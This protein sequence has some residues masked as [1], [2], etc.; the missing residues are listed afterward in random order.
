MSSSPTWTRRLLKKNPVHSFTDF[1]MHMN[2]LGILKNFR[3]WFR[4]H[5]SS[6]DFPFLLS[7]TYANLLESIWV[8]R[9]LST[10]NWQSMQI[11]LTHT[12]FFHL[13]MDCHVNMKNNNNIC[14][15]FTERSKFISCCYI[16]LRKNI[17]KRHYQDNW[18]HYNMSRRLG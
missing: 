12:D 3:F 4:V 15:C 14:L 7:G 6:W 10:L 1:H 16:L 11:F 9:L 2:H 17:I 18:W 5:G 8:A 13:I